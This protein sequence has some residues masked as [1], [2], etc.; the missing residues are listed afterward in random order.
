MLV[1]EYMD[2]ALR[3]SILLTCRSFRSLVFVNYRF[4]SHY[5]RY[6]LTISLNPS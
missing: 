2:T 1:G 3:A 6:D 4:Y 5:F